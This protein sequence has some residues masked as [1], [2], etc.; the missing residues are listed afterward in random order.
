MLGRMPCSG[1]GRWAAVV[2][3]L[4]QAASPALAQDETEP[5]EF[6]RTGPY[7]AVHGGYAHDIDGNLTQYGV[8]VYTEQ[9]GSPVIGLRAGY[10]MRPPMAVELQLD[11]LTGTSS[12]ATVLGGPPLPPLPP[13]TTTGQLEISA[14]SFTPN[15][16]VYLLPGRIQ[17]YTVIGIGLFWSRIGDASPPALGLFEERSEVS[18][19]VRAGG[20][21]SIQIDQHV[22]LELGAEYIRPYGHNSSLRHVEFT[23]AVMYRF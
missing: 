16:R 18:F 2:V 8:T 14:L 21:L 9:T 3:V 12:N 11:Y 10:R 23:G 5:E 6:G 4:L 7:V 19:L 13:G 20:G 17:P 22:A 15:L 1:S